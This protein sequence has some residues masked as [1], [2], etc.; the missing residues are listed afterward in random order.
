MMG[1]ELV[2]GSDLLL[3]ITYM[4]TTRGRGKVDIIYRR[5]DDNFIDPITFD[6]NSCIGVPGLF[7]P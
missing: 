1:V 2:Q 6:R 7:V 4:K 3:S 5:I